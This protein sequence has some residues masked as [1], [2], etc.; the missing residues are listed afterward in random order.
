MFYLNIACVKNLFFLLFKNL[1]S[2]ILFFNYCV[3]AIVIFFTPKNKSC[4]KESTQYDDI[5]HTTTINN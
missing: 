5:L 2:G 1:F 4:Y 3:Y